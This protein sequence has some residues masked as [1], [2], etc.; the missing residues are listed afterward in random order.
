M[1]KSLKFDCFVNLKSVM[2]LC[3]PIPICKPMSTQS[4]M[5]T[6]NNDEIQGHANIY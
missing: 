2:I 4:V 5:T 6:D 3:N 1:V